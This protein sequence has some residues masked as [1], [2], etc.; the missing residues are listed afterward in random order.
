MAEERYQITSIPKV[1]ND[2]GRNLADDL[3]NLG[4]KR[5]Q[6]RIFSNPDMAKELVR[7]ESSPVYNAKAEIIQAVTTNRGSA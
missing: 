6:R 3:K 1:D 7:L 5:L 4:R 2:R